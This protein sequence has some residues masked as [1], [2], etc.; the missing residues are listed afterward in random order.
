MREPLL[1]LSGLEPFVL[2]NE[3]PF[4]NVGERTNVTGSKRFARLIKSDDVTAATEVAVDQVRGPLGHA[5]SATA[6]AKP[7]SLATERH[8][9]VEP[10]PRAPKPGEAGTQGATS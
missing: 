10:T 7:A 9:P 3:I 5:P 2:T 6:L 8:E 4:V 1:R